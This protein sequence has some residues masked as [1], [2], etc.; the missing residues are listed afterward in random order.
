MPPAQRWMRNSIVLALTFGCGA[1]ARASSD[2]DALKLEAEPPAERPA[3][4][5]LRLALE[6]GL[7]RLQERGTGWRDS[8]R[9]AIDLRYARPMASDL[10]FKLSYR[11]DDLHPVQPGQRSTRHS[12]R[13]AYLDWRLPDSG[14]SLQAGRINLRNGPAFG[15]NPSDFFRSGALQVITTADPVALRENRLGTV[16]LNLRRPWAQGELS[17]ALAPKLAEPGSD[18]NQGTSLNLAA[19]NGSHRTLLGATARF[20]DRVSGQGLALLQA[21]GQHRLGASLTALASDAAVVYGEWSAGK[22][23]RLLQAAAPGSGSTL[24][25][26]ALGITYTLAGGWAITAEAHYNGAGLDSS[27]WRA[28]QAQ[29]VLAAQGLALRAQQDLELVARRGW[30]L[31]AS[32]KGLGLKQLDFTGFVRQNA[33]DHSRLAWAELRYHWPQF[34][35]ALQW[36]HS[37]GRPA[38]EYAMAPQRQVLQLLG[39]RYF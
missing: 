14:A 21:G 23:N 2:D 29:G 12:L 39:V 24:H 1:L 30:L 26:A 17:L 34:D 20:S 37:A 15:Y 33:V 5:P 32:K 11:L 31:Y 10:Q 22:T 28:L 16:M 9:A 35:L 25:Q 36:Q 18:G 3:E 38:T 7:G 19:T 4:S 27:G 6:G 13:E 8:H